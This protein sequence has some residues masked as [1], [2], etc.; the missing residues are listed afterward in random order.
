MDNSTH[1]SQ[2]KP[3]FHGRQSPEEGVIVGYAAI[4]ATLNLEMPMVKPIL[5]VCEHNRKYQSEDWSVLPKSYLPED[6]PEFKEIEALY[7]H[8]VFALK[9]EG[10]NL[11][12]FKRLSQYYREAQLTELVSIEPT[13][14]YSRRI[15]FILEWLMCRPLSGK[16]G[17]SK[18]GYVPLVDSKQ[19]YGVEGIKS[20]R[21]LVINNLPGTPEFCPMVRKTE[22][23]EKYIHAGLSNQKNAFIKGIRKE[24]VQRASAF[25]L[26]RDSKA[27]FSIEG[28]SPKSKRA[29]RWGQVI[30]QA[31]LNELSRDELIRLQQ[32]V[33][34]NTRFVEMGFRKKGG[35]VGEHDRITGE[36]IPD[37]ISAKWQDV[38]SLLK[39]LIETNTILIE[40][41]ID[42]VISAAI[43]A[44]G[45]V[46][47]HPFEDGNGRIHRYLVHHVLAKKQF[48]QQGIIF[49][50]SASI[51]DHIED[52]RK[53]LE[54]YSHPL[55][56]YIEWEETK[57]HNVKVLN[58]TVDYY[59]YYDATS[60][61]EFLYDCVFDTIENIIP[62]EINYLT[63]YDEF[64]NRMDDDFEMP[65]R[66][67]AILVNFLLQHNGVLSKR[68]KEKHFSALTEGEIK[69]IERTFQEVFQ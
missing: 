27:S 7:K 54:S 38:P 16:E 57:D 21:H 56:E 55:L 12:L 31:G 4:I 52:Y 9:Y 36:P 14:Q 30:G 67:V 11:L 13:G 34:E 60:Q 49:P 22:K 37:H 28:E 48:S 46:F 15:W 63:Q 32:V 41:E 6:K 61:A 64:K 43:V 35:F 5:L 39:G 62:S 17:L 47:I 40:S 58:D 65:D 66:L 53:V 29:T 33:I 59:R 44:F 25:L 24:I 26:L 42:A 8:L 10:I 50:V 1:F 68:A 19:Q 45:F 18:K 20:P 51:L 69:K 2:R 23:L 3:V